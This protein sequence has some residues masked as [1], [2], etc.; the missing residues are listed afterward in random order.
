MRWSRAAMAAL[1]ASRFTSHSNG[2]G[3]VSSKSFRSNTSD[4]SGLAKMPKFNRCASPHSCT[5]IPDVG[6]VARSRPIC[7]AEPR[8]KA[9]GDSIIRRLRTG[10]RSWRRFLLTSS[11]T[12][13]GS[14]RSGE[15]AQ[16]PCAERGTATRRARPAAR[17]SPGKGTGAPST[18]GRGSEASGPAGAGVAALVMEDDLARCQPARPD[19]RADSHRPPCVRSRVVREAQPAR[20]SVSV[21]VL[22][23]PVRGVTGATAMSGRAGLVAAGSERGGDERG[24]GDLVERGDPAVAQ[25]SR[26]GRSQ[27]RTSPSRHGRRDALPPRRCHPHRCT[28]GARRAASGK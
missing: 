19:R 3:Q 20:E 9:K 23:E 14:R 2:P 12:S 4:L 1:A 24:V 11:T 13:T 21:Q 17:R 8:K 27:R 15:G 5:S 10:T 25:A 7:S 28:P 18:C 26:Y 16:A 22:L 6:V